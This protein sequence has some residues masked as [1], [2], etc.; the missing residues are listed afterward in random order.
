MILLLRWFKVFNILFIGGG[1]PFPGFGQFQDYNLTNYTY[2][3]VFTSIACPDNITDFDNQC[4]YNISSSCP[5]GFNGVITCI[6]G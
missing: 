2:N 4:S 3:I 5:S 6:N 1:L